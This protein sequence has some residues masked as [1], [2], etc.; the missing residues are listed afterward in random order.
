MLEEA[1]WHVK[2]TIGGARF[3]PREGA[4]NVVAEVVAVVGHVVEVMKEYGGR[5]AQGDYGENR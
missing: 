2:S 5:L 1:A 3:G 4:G